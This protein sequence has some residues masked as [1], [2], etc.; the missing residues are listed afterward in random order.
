MRFCFTKVPAVKKHVMI[1][2]LLRELTLTDTPAGPMGVQQEG[3]ML[4][5]H[6]VPCRAEGQDLDESSLYNHESSS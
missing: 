2:A 5:S 3:L 6:A 4:E 1:G